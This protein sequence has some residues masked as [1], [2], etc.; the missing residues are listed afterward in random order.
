V[1]PQLVKFKGIALDLLF[2][3]RCLG[4]RVEGEL[5]CHTCQKSL[6]RIV[7]PI[8]PKCGRPQASG[9]PCPVC[10]T[11]QTS[12]DGIRSPLKFEGIIREA[13]HQLKYK[14]LRSI[15][16]PLALLLRDYLVQYPLP[17]QV[18]V[19]VPLHSKRLRQRGYNQSVLLA[20]ELSKLLFIPVVDDCLT[21]SKFASPQAQT[22]SVHERHDNVR[23]AFSCL[24]PKL[25]NTQVLLIDDVSTS[26]ATLDACAA[27]LKQAGA[28]SIWGL[29]LAR[30]T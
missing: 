23:G 5:L 7:P 2:P 30:E 9:L 28:T 1:L 20:R 18:L 17:V 24:S 10:V 21:R 26:G 4:C 13:I 15:A 16:G 19:P 29:V 25:A 6:P 11:W 22:K 3:Q 14:N 12:I 27:A 8:C